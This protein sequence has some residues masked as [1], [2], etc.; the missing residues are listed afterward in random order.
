MTQPKLYLS[1]FRSVA[2]DHGNSVLQA[3]MM[4]AL[5][6]QA[7]AITDKSTLS[8]PFPEYSSFVCVVAEEDCFIDIG[9]KPDPVHFIGEGE[10]LYYGVH[11]EYRLAVCS[12]M[13]GDE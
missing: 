11:P 3:P 5:T 4:P 6:A 10:R 8:E 7:L 9:I 13:N 1:V 12:T 2:H